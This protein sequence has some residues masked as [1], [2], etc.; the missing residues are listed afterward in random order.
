MVSFTADPG[1]V[2]Q[3]SAGHPVRPDRALIHYRWAAMFIES[4]RAG[5]LV[6]A[7][8]DYYHHAELSA[9]SISFLQLF[10]NRRKY[11]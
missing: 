10:H 9:A 7:L 6:A 3:D 5:D 8:Q 2:L 11:T 1:S 4:V